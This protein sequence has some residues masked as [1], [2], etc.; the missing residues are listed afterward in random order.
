M[1]LWQRI[2][3]VRRRAKW[4]LRTSERGRTDGRPGAD[5]RMGGWA[6]DTAGSRERSERSV[7]AQVK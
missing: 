1:D 4:G 2:G 5:W 6:E 3:V 7:W